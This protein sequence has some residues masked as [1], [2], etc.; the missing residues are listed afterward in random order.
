M[1][2]VYFNSFA[3]VGISTFLLALVTGKIHVPSSFE[4]EKVIHLIHPIHDS[5]WLGRES[6]VSMSCSRLVWVALIV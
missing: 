4:I 5:G 3:Y 6:M 1:V 2:K